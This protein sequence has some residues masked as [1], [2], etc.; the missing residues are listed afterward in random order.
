F[1]M[2]RLLRLPKLQS[3]L[4]QPLKQQVDQRQA[5]FVPRPLRREVPEDVKLHALAATFFVLLLVIYLFMVFSARTFPWITPALSLC[6]LLGLVA[7]VYGFISFHFPRA[8]YP[9]ALLVVL[10]GIVAS[11]AADKHRFSGLDYSNKQSLDK[12]SY[13][14]RRKQDCGLLK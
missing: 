7:D 14:A 11:L 10:A 9:V 4:P 12:D 2:E 13:E 3:R 5:T 6:I 8:V 1:L